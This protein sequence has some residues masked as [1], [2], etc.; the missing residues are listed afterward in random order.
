M[1]PIHPLTGLSL[2]VLVLIQGC[3]L[4]AQTTSA[5]TTQGAAA[6]ATAG[7]WSQFV[8]PT[9]TFV[10]EAQ[11]LEGSTLL[12]QAVPDIAKMMRD[13]CLEICKQLYADNSVPRNN[14]TNLTLKLLNAPGTVAWKAGDAPNIT[15]GIGAQYLATFYHNNGNQLDLVA[16]EVKGVLSHEGAHGYQY[17][18]K[19]CGDYDGSSVHWGFVEGEADAVRAEL[20]NWTP[21]RMPQKGGT[22]NG[23]YTKGGFFLAWCKHHKKPTFLIELNRCA[24]SMATFTWEAAFQQILGQSVQSV[25]DEYQAT[26][27]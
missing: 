1:S 11:G 10:D 23:G 4:G 19:N 26:L 15:I 16:K 13:Q 22:W 6:G 18:P 24:Q 12:H 9:V 17:S 25:W 27:P 2:G 7:D 20:N 14:F 21:T 3:S 8:P 5:T